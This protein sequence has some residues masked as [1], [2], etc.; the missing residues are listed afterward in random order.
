LGG[1][2]A[3][4]GSLIGAGET[5]GRADGAVD[6]SAVEEPE[7][8]VTVGC[9]GPAEDVDTAGA[10]SIGRGAILAFIGALLAGGSVDEEASSTGASHCDIVE[11]GSIDAFGAGL[12]V[13]C[14][15]FRAIEGGAWVALEGGGGVEVESGEAGAGAIGWIEE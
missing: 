8:T 14:T 11:C 7:D 5:G 4:A 2:A 6:I 13:G 15:A 1:I 9:A 12:R 3:G 10:N